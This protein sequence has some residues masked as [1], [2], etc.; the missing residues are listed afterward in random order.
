MN[1]FARFNWYFNRSNLGN[2]NRYKHDT[3]NVFIVLQEHASDERNA[4]V[5]TQWHNDD[6]K[7][8]HLIIVKDIYAGKQFY[9]SNIPF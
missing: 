3:S 4:S 1:I 8:T 5:S 2:S 7:T 9:I 6:F